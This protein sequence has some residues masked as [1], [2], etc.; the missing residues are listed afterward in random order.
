MSLI[1]LS[2]AG[3]ITRV[4]LDSPAN[5]NALSTALMRELLT[6]LSE[7]VADDQARVDRKSVV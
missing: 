6:A 4:V 5:R 3:G 7:I 1:K 2:H